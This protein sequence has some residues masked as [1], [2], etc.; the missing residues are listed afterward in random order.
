LSL[1]LSELVLRKIPEH[2]IARISSGECHVYGSII[3]SM[4]TGRIVGH[5]QETSELASLAGT[6]LAAPASLPFQIGNFGVDAIGHSVSFIQNEQI[7]AG[8]AALQ[9]MQLAGIALGTAAIGVSVAGFAVLSAKLSRIEAKI[10]QIH[11]KLEEMARVLD[12][13]R[14]D[15]LATDFVRLRTALEQLDEA[16]LLPE[17]NLQFRSVSTEAHFLANQFHRRASEL[18]HGA[19]ETVTMAEPFAEALCL[20]ANVRVTA[21]MASGDDAAAFAAAKEGAALLSDIVQHVHLGDATLASVSR[22]IPIATPQWGEAL[23]ATADQ[24][25]P[26]V[27]AYRAREQ[28]AAATCLTLAELQLQQISGR[29]WLETARDDAGGPLLCLLPKLAR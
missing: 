29:A 18:L 22:E 12:A 28:A 26:I 8:I 27:E 17:P 9:S 14:A 21:R 2:L 3:R 25:R 10:D 20:A 23:K 19:P 24:L 11:P 4:T 5:L 1:L 7:K 13:V 6:L 16:W 15:Q